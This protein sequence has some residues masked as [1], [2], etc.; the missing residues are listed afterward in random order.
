MLGVRHEAHNAAGLIAHTGNAVDGTVV[1]IGIAEDHAALALDAGDVII[2]GL[3]AALAVLGRHQDLLALL[4]LAGPRGGGIGHLKVGIGA[5]EVQALIA[6]Q[7]AWQQARL[8]KDLEAIADAEHRHA[9]LR[10][11][12][13][14]LHHRRERGNRARAQVVTIR[15]TARHYYRIHAVQI[16]ICVPEAFHLCAGG[17]GSA[18]GIY[19]IQG[20]GESDYS[21]CGGH[22]LDLQPNNLVVLDDGIGQQRGGYLLQVLCG[23]GVIDLELE[24]LSLAHIAD[25]GYPDATQ[26]ADD[27]LALRIQNL[28][29]GH[30]IDNYTSH[31]IFALLYGA[32]VCAA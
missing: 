10:T 30:D 29:L 12:D 2:A 24:A 5:V 8:S 23:D 14:G 9:L 28:R 25:T 16:G 3:E 4:K 22:L 1:I 18:S 21:D 17:A 6:G 15:K 32:L 13:N 31:E 11:I 20:S 19:I 26:R 7:R 27:G